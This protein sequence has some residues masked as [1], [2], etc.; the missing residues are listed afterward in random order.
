MAGRGT[1]A[2]VNL[3]VNASAPVNRGVSFAILAKSP[4]FRDDS[5]LRFDGTT[6][7]MH[8]KYLKDLGSGQ[9]FMHSERGMG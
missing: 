1:Y 2:R 9:G 6:S 7:V 8:P 3:R 4:T 5:A